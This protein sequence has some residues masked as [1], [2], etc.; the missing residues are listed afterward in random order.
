VQNERF[1][2]DIDPKN[3]SGILITWMKIEIAG[4]SQDI[5]GFRISLDIPRYLRMTIFILGYP[6]T[7]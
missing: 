3:A 5:I 6:R 4:I 7:S 1:T 2:F